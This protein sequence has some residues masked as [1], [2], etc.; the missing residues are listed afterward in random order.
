MSEPRLKARLFVQAALRQA[1]GRGVFGAVVRTGDD[2]AGD[3]V[4]LLRARDD[5]ITV[6]AQARTGDGSPAWMR[7]AG[8]H[9]V[10]RTEANAYV[11]RATER[12][13]DLWVVEF[14]VDDG[15]PPFEAVLLPDR[16]GP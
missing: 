15:V 3:I 1:A 7:A 5:R 10:D 14:D 13:P 11:A 9:A 8:G 6:L 16:H 4:V 2:D 12:D